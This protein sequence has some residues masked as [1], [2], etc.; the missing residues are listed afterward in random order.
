LLFAFML[1]FLAVR[2]SSPQVTSPA[3][4]ISSKPTAA[5][6][7]T[8]TEGK[9][10]NEIV[11]PLPKTP[12]NGGKSEIVPMLYPDFPDDSVENQLIPYLTPS[13]R[14]RPS[15]IF[16]INGF[17]YSNGEIFFSEF[18]VEDIFYISQFL[19]TFPAVQIALRADDNKFLSSNRTL[20][21]LYMKS[22]R[23][24]LVDS[25]VSKDQ[26]KV[27][28]LIGLEEV[29]KFKLLNEFSNG[30]VYFRVIKN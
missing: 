18:L 11:K 25:G 1:L 23:D 20:Q 27:Q 5:L 30:V 22:F 4:K 2:Q 21:D 12:K 6:A 7:E 26:I 14:T 16:K 28:Y 13:E 8:S 24:S 19:K 9:S 17:K 29:R 10:K 15:S 3:S